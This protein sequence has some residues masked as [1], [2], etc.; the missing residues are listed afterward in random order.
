MISTCF[1]SSAA[2]VAAG[3]TQERAGKKRLLG[4]AVMAEAL[5]REC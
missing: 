5:C 2:A 1:G 3:V 4:A